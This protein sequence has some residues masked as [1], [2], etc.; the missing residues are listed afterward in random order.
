MR[1]IAPIVVIAA[2]AALLTLYIGAYYQLGYRFDHKIQIMPDGSVMP[3]NVTERTYM[4]KWAWAIFQP[5]GWIESKVRGVDVE[6]HYD[7][8][9]TRGVSS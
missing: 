8:S 1:S 3:I 2:M 6:I 7:D 5:A 4:R 9:D